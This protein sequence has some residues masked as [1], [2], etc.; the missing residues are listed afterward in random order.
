MSTLLLNSIN[1]KP[2]IKYSGLL[3]IT[4]LVLLSFILT[5]TLVVIYK[6]FLCMLVSAVMFYSLGMHGLL[7]LPKAINHLRQLPENQWLI[8]DKQGDE[9]LAVLASE[10]FISASLLVLNFKLID[11][12]GTKTV[13]L[14]RDSLSFSQFR[15]LKVAIT[16]INTTK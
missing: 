5:A 2:S 8:Q 13:I 12:R 7:I 16:L 10:G 14:L 6:L 4:W 3:L 1:I 15:H 9:W 11:R